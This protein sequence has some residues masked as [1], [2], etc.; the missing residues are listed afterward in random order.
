MANIKTIFCSSEIS[1]HNIEFE[2]FA[3]ESNEITLKILDRFDDRIT[4]VILDLETAIRFAKEI[5][6]EIAIIKNDL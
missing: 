1:E 6:R 2:V 3:N 5:K 4:Y